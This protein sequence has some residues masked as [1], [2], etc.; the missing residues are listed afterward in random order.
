MTHFATPLCPRGTKAVSAGFYAPLI[1]RAQ[2]NVSAVIPL[3]QR[4]LNPRRWMIGA[5]P[6]SPSPSR[7]TGYSYCSG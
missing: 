5:V 7:T 2:D 6:I 3:E 1:F 4:R